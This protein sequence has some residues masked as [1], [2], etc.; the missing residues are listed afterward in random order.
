LPSVRFRSKGQVHTDRKSLDVFESR[1]PQGT[2]VPKSDGRVK[3]F[4]APNYRDGFDGKLERELNRLRAT[5]A[6]SLPRYVVF[7]NETLGIL[8]RK[9]PRTLIELE[10]VKGIGPA[11]SAK[12]GAEILKA[13]S[14]LSPRNP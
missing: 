14:R 13:I 6:G 9:K 7:N 3:E 2:T 12:Y 4:R 1:G 5:L 8:V 10:S 11:R